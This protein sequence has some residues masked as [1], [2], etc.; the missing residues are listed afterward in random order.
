MITKTKLKTYPFDPAKYLETEE[1]M[2]GY[3]EVCM[4][5]GDP[6]LIAD[7][8]GIIARAKGMTQISRETG[9]SREA[10]YR[11][12]SKTGNPEFATVLKVCNALGLR[13]HASSI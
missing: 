8:L 3:L 7:A 4:E 5:D 9:I 2:A 1:A 11:A 10:L 12:L 6:A 13:L